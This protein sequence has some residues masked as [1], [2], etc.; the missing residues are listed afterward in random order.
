VSP[1]SLL[2]FPFAP[3]LSVMAGAGYDQSTRH[4]GDQPFLSDLGR[5]L[6]PSR[7]PIVMAGLVPAI[8]GF[9]VVL[10]HPQHV[11]RGPIASRSGTS[12]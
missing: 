10:H 5:R 8:H 9:L 3:A 6:R 7:L 1:F 11:L 12:G 2:V 4:A